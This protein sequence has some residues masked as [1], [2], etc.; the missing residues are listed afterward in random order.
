MFFLFEVWFLVGFSGAFVVYAGS[1]VKAE[2]PPETRHDC[3]V[4]L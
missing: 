1:C 3:A 4:F 2:R